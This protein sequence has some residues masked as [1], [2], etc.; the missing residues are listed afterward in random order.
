MVFHFR[1]PAS[2]D[3]PKP[4]VT[5][6]P[7]PRGAKGTVSQLKMILES[8]RATE[9]M[10]RVRHAGPMIIFK[11]C[12]KFSFF[13]NMSKLQPITSRIFSVALSK[14]LQKSKRQPFGSFPREA[15]KT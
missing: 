6:A 14:Q 1:E 7:S 11:T 13:G 15:R 10:R 2:V 4:T 9:K 5:A 3:S 12:Q 8:D